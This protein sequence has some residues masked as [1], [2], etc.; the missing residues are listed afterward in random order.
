[1]EEEMASRPRLR[2]GGKP[3]KRQGSS[4]KKGDSKRVKTEKKKEEAWNDPEKVLGDGNC[5]TYQDGTKIPVCT[6]SE[7]MT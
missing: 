4:K 3:V 6:F 7:F 5:Q 1:M 2:G